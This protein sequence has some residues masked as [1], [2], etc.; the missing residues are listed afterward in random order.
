MLA[1][2]LLLPAS[3]RA[4]G[5]GA[6][7]A[8]ARDA[9]GAGQAAYDQ[10]AF[11]VALAHF[12]RAQAL[13][14]NPDLAYHVALAADSLGQTSRA[15]AAY[16]TYLG[17]RPESPHRAFVAE[18]IAKLSASPAAATPPAALAAAS[19]ASE[20]ELPA[21]RGLIDEAMAESAAKN[22]DEA[23]ALFG[24]AHALFPNARTH[25]GLAMIEFELRNY[26]A[27]LVQIEAS[28]QSTVRPLDVKLRL[29]AETLR[30]RAQAFVGRL[31]V[32]TTPTAAELRLDGQPLTDVEPARAS[33]IVTLGE[34]TVE[35]FAPDFE[36][37]KRR[38][39]VRGGEEQTLAI[40]FTRRIDPGAQP[41]EKRAWLRSPWLWSAAGVVVAGAVIGTA[42]ALRGDDSVVRTP[43]SGG[44]LG[45]ELSGPRMDAR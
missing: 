28:L 11:A 45:V 31:V 19:P 23:L 2:G 36:S 1:V 43:S 14:P 34:H 32:T 22:Y 25:R 44:S 27:C 7:G 37:E 9:L 41:S 6:Q 13:Q 18:R 21:Y 17:A 20:P 8:D 39:R 42:L 4:E 30:A 40:A 5:T 24:R 10:G 16:A 12:E 15:L 26:P 3:V 38:L 35:A 29:D 33:L